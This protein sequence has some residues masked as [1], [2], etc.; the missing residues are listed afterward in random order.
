M[1][2]FDRNWQDV[3]RFII[4]YLRHRHA[5]GLILRSPASVVVD[6]AGVIAATM[7]P[8]ADLPD[9]AGLGKDAIRKQIL[10]QTGQD[11]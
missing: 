11:E 5:G 3:P 10:L 6:N 9:R 4:G 2:G 8:L 1:H 7:A